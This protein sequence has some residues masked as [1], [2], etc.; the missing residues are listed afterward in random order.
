MSLHAF[1]PKPAVDLFES[2]WDAYPRR[3]AKKDARKAWDQLKP[4]TAL[5]E[6]ML[7]ALELQVKSKQWREGFIPLPATW[8]RGERWEDELSEDDFYRARL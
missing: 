4:D 8:I 1:Q 2:F 7:D 5:V 3:Q 6:K